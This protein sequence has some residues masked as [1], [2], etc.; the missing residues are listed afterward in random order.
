M[1]LYV[2]C[3]LSVTASSANSLSHP[4]KQV[5]SYEIELN[6]KMETDSEWL[7]SIQKKERVT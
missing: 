5:N 1:Y 2:E 4:T 3:W 7:H 6:G